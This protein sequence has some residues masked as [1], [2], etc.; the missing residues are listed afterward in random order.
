MSASSKSAIRK[1]ALNRKA[2]HE[3]FVLERVEAGIELRGTE[4]KSVREG[5][6]TLTGGYAGFEGRIPVLYDVHI[7]PYE[8]G[9]Q[10][11]HDPARPKRLL[12]QRREIDRLLGAVTQKGHTLVPLSVY[13]KGA[14]AK[15]EL[16]LCRGKQNPDKR[17]TLRKKTADREAARDIARGR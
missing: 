9:N 3:F 13:F 7:A 8:Y 10:F 2:L 16:G 17:E 6:V 12:L 15:L 5:H 11:N 1:V 4:V 14:H